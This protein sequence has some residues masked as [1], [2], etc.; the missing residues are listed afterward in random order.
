MDKQSKFK[1]L[2]KKVA[3][4]YIKKGMSKEKAQTIGDKVAYMQG[5]KKMGKQNMINKMIIAK[6]NR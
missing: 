5:V 4:Q 6:K 2:S 1:V 3:K